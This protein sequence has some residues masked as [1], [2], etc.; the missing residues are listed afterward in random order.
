LKNTHKI[1]EGKNKKKKENKSK[2]E[3]NKYIKTINGRFLL[4][5]QTLQTK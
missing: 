1:I 5:K 4:I 2:T 3:K